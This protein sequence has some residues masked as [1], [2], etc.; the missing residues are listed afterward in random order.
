MKIINNTLHYHRKCIISKSIVSTEQP[1]LVYLLVIKEATRFV[2]YIIST[3]GV[4]RERLWI[5]SRTRRSNAT[6]CLYIIHVI[7]YGMMLNA[8]GKFS[9]ALADVFIKSPDGTFK[10]ISI[11]N[12]V[13]HPWNRSEH[14]KRAFL[15]I[16]NCRCCRNWRALKM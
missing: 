4:F 12:I 1:K 9:T 15:L 14:A 16:C 11:A 5:R 10:C 2:Q 6:L 3:F 8:M 13:P 7:T